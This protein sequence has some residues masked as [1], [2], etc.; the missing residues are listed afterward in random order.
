M[1]M[2]FVHTSPRAAVVVLVWAQKALIVIS[3]TQGHGMETLDPKVYKQSYRVRISA[4]RT[5]AAAEHNCRAN[6]SKIRCHY[7]RRWPADVPV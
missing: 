1:S 7:I 5:S 2:T 4:P 6:L 3:F